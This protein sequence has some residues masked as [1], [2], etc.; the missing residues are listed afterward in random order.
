MTL[1]LDKIHQSLKEE[2]MVDWFP[3]LSLF[4]KEMNKIEM[5][6]NMLDKEM[7]RQRKSSMAYKRL[8]EAPMSMLRLTRGGVEAGGVQD[9]S[10]HPEALRHHYRELILRIRDAENLDPPTEAELYAAG[11][12]ATW[13]GPVAVTGSDRT[14]YANTMEYLMGRIIPSLAEKLPARKN[15]SDDEMWHIEHNL[16]HLRDDFKW[17]NGSRKATLNG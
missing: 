10:N 8:K 4:V 3:G 7:N 6:W 1:L 2:L 5:A 17:V 13:H 16:K 15:W 9:L 12:A 11:M 14:S